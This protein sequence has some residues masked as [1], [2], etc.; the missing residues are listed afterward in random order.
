MY[1]KPKSERSKMKQQHEMQ[2]SLT[3]AD[4]T[5]SWHADGSNAAYTVAVVES[6]STTGTV[7]TAV[8]R[9][10]EEINCSTEQLNAL[11]CLTL[12][13]G[14]LPSTKLAYELTHSILPDEQDLRPIP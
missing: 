14:E 5:I 6:A 4:M 2:G 11:L 8:T 3:V 1:G 9:I 10:S 12:C 7:T 13:G